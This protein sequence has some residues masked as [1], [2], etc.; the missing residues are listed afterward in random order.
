VAEEV[1]VEEIV[2]V[3]GAMVM[4]GRWVVIRG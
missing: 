3:M 2:I 1:V 4:V